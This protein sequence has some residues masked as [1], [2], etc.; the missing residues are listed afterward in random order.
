M[1][2]PIGLLAATAVMIPILVHLWRV[3][4]GKTLRIGSIALIE[5]SARTRSTSLRIHN[6]PLFLLRCLLI[7]T[8][9][10]LLA[11]PVWQK[12]VKANAKGWILIP[13][14][15]QHIAYAAYKQ[16]ID[17]L[18]A[19]QWE[20]HEFGNGFIDLS[21][22]ELGASPAPV[23]WQ[24]G[25]QAGRPRIYYDPGEPV[26]VRPWALV[27]ELDTRLPAGYPVQVFA[28]NSLS[29]YAGA[30]PNT[31]LSLQWHSYAP[32]ENTAYN[33]NTAGADSA[34]TNITIYPGNNLADARYVKAALEAIAEATGKRFQITSLTG[35]QTPQVPQQLIIRLDE[36]PATQLLQNLT[37]NGIL[38]QYDTGKVIDQP[39]YL[40]HPSS[41]APGNNQYKI[42][43]YVTGPAEG[44]PVWT[45]ANGLPL[46]TV[47]DTAGKQAYHYKSRFNP[48]WGDLVWEDGFAAL[49]LPFAI[50]VTNIDIAYDQRAL[51][52]RQAIPQPAT[53]K[54]NNA[55]NNTN[56]H[57]AS[58]YSLTTLLGI[59]AGLLFT[60]ERI[61]AWWQQ[62]PQHA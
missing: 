4:K 29:Q 41:A 6:W 30:R 40:Q 45:L 21:P 11:S 22:K 16:K 55:I 3:R 5:G 9:A 23:E 14:A 60:A 19:A 37:T 46:L 34:T 57:N 38:F 18:L 15:E 8:L 43:R 47:E 39:S 59:I 7:F 53:G 12:D 50:P 42:H 17:S 25:G 49:L 27:K 36:Q 51:D 2:N 10:F 44:H 56:G 35:N 62:R 58:Q 32:I 54:K 1:L 26:E 24:Q 52:D 13:A 31:H 33:P 28:S 61:L 20:L 48:G